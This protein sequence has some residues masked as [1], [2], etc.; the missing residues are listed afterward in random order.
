MAARS[1]ELS[2]GYVSPNV[3]AEKARRGDGND[4]SG[5]KIELGK[6]GQVV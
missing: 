3:S 4:G 2:H 6:K 5:N 1:R